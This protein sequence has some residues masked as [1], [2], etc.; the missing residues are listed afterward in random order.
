MLCPK[1]GYYA[2][3][4]ENVCPSCGN[5]LNHPNG[6][7]PEGAEAIRQGKRAREAVRKRPVQ[8]SAIMEEH[9]R[10]SG[11]SHATVEMP[12]IK[13]ER[14]IEK[15]YFDSMTVSENEYCIAFS[16]SDTGTSS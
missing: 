10:R 3:S 16:G 14:T 9:K 1:C 2:E 8:D 6:N 11:A 12:A 5:I 13:D 7:K 15:D 4:E